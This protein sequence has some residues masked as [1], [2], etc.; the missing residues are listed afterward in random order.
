[1]MGP[2]QA[3]VESRTHDQIDLIRYFGTG[4][5]A[6]RVESRMRELGWAWCREGSYV[7]PYVGHSA[8]PT[9]A[10]TKGNTVLRY[11]IRP[12]KKAD[13]SY[14]WRCHHP[15]FKKGDVFVEFLEPVSCAVAQEVQGE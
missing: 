7:G 8:G 14:V 2:I 4:K 6:V 3:L 11:N 12:W 5:E 9:F 10:Y 13:G 15:A 1:M